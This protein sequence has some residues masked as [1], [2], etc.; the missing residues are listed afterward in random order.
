MYI[1]FQYLNIVYK[2]LLDQTKEFFLDLSFANFLTK[3]RSA[4]LSMYCVYK[5]TVISKVCLMNYS[6]SLKLDLLLEINKIYNELII[7]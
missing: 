2:N 4:F 5:I 1:I 3:L 6:N 7:T